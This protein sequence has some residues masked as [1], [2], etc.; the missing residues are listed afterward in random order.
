[1]AGLLH[2]PTR[3]ATYR[4]A[5]IQGG[6]LFFTLVTAG[7]K[8]IFC[9]PFARQALRGALLGCKARWPFRC[10]AIVLMPDHFHTIWTLP[11]GDTDYSRRWAW[12]KREFTCAW[13][14]AG[15]AEEARTPGMRRGRRRGVLQPRFWEHVIR[16]ERDFARHLDYIH[17][18]PVKHGLVRCPHDWPHSSFHRWVARALYVGSW[19]CGCRGGAVPPDF[20]GIGTAAGE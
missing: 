12:I 14:G 18:N 10:D 19:C 1:M 8:P 6:T 15:G 4:R 9:D 3:M 16:D 17:Y 20:G 11:P 7:R 5:I 2:C 13:L